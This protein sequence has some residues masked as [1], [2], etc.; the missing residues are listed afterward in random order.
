MPKTT[1]ARAEGE[2]KFTYAGYL[3]CGGRIDEENYERV[4][5]RARQEKHENFA[6]DQTK[7]TAD[8]SGISLEAIGTEAGI[9]PRVVYGILRHDE[10]PAETPHHH[11]QMSDQL[12]LV[13]ALRMLE[14]GD[15][16]ARVIAKHPHMSF[17]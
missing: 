1:T 14:Q 13:E 11:A 12:L 6:A 4:M 7:V 5:E 16:A 9:D 10:K 2:P 3:A 8:I 15:A 17:R